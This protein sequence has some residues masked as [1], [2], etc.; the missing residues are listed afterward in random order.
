MP[1]FTVTTDDG[2]GP[3]RSEERLDYKDEKAAT[4]DAQLALSNMASD[5]QPHG[6]AAHWG[7]GVQD[8]TGRQ[9][10]RADLC[11]SSKD[12]DDLDRDDRESDAAAIE[13]A[14]Y[15]GGG[16]PRE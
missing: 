14:C 1:K 11:F 7:V 2:H 10:Y 16:G 13:V 12:G 9:V 15:L 3:E 4:D 8:E 5:V 6:K